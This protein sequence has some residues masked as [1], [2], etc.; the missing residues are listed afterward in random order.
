LCFRLGKVPALEEQGQQESP[1]IEVKPQGL[2]PFP[3][4]LPSLGLKAKPLLPH[5]EQGTC[6]T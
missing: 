5:P 4:A 2:R 1:F 6:W 3:E